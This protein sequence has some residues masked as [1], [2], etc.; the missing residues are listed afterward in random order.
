MLTPQLCQSNIPES[1]LTVKGHYFTIERKV[2][3]ALMYLATGCSFQVVSEKFGCGVSIVSKTL[4][5]FIAAMLSHL[6]A[7]IKWPSTHT[8]IQSTKARMQS[9]KRFS[10]CMGA[11]D[12][13]HIKTVMSAKELTT[14]WYDRK[15]NYSMISQGIVDAD[16]RFLDIYAG[17]PRPANSKRVLQNS[18][19]FCLAQ[20]NQRLNGPTFSHRHYTI[21]EYIIGN[22]GFYSLP[23]L[24]IPFQE[25]CLPSQSRYNYRLSSTRMVVER[26]FGRLKNAWRIID[27]VVKIHDIKRV[28]KVITV[29]CM[30]HNMAITHGMQ[31]LNEIDVTLAQ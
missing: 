6:H 22:G 12:C 20:T 16:M 19:F 11:I 25:P 2:G 14:N 10:N 7:I 29:C 24:F 4:D 5:D 1:L 30:L 28:P 26:A 27:E 15:G 23:W 21:R 13:T 17:F 18:S 31:V 9:S 3:V 8:E